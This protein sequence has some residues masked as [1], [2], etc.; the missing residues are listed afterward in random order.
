MTKIM[1]L[2]LI[3]TAAIVIGTLFAIALIRF[4]IKKADCRTL[5]PPLELRLYYDSDSECF[6]VLLQRLINSGAVRQYDVS[7]SVVDLEKSKDSE[8]W[9]RKLEKKLGCRMEIL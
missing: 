1:C 8:M 3:T 7:I 9:L 2:E 4:L 6:E 5:K